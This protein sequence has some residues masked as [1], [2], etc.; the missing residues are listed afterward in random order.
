MELKIKRI[1]R[2]VMMLFMLLFLIIIVL[3]LKNII[4]ARWKPLSSGKDA[5]IDV[6]FPE[7]GDLIFVSES[8]NLKKE[9]SHLDKLENLTLYFT[10][11]LRKN[12]NVSK[13]KNYSALTN[14]NVNTNAK[15]D[16]K[17][18]ANKLEIKIN[19][20]DFD[21]FSNDLKNNNYKLALSYNQPIRNVVGQTNHE[22][23]FII[24]DDIKAPKIKI[25]REGNRFIFLDKKHDSLDTFYVSN[26]FI[27]KSETI[28]ST[29]DSSLF[30]ENW[31]EDSDSI[32]F[33][34][35]LF[36]LLLPACLIVESLL[37]FP[38]IIVF[39]N[40]YS[41]IKKEEIV[42]N[43]DSLMEPYLIESIIDEKIDSINLIITCIIDLV[44]KGNLE[45]VDNN[46]I[47]LKSISNINNVEK[48]IIKLL[49]LDGRDIISLKECI[50]TTIKI[51]DIND[52]IKNDKEFSTALYEKMK[53]IKAMIK[54]ELVKKKI[55]N[56]FWIPFLK[57]IRPIAMYF[58]FMSALFV[59]F[60]S[61]DGMA[62]GN[63]VLFFS[64]TLLVLASYNK[65]NH[66]FALA[67][68]VPT[69]LIELVVISS[70]TFTRIDYVFVL[71]LIVE[72]I[73][74]L[75][76]K[77]ANVYVYTK[78]GREEYKKA[79]IF[80]KFLKNYSL[81]KKRDIDGVIVYDDYLVYATA[82][83]IMSSITKKISQNLVNYNTLLH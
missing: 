8:V 59:S 56:P 72:A 33:S 35:R 43:S 38:L 63:F 82:F 40:N 45:N 80:K 51:S 58:A 20:D 73:I 81:I 71:F 74:I 14:L 67:I 47:T 46:R 76:I 66:Y 79:R 7:N 60:M 57:I 39:I 6:Y 77:K 78:K 62:I 32:I 44:S 61:L 23:S 37:L 36:L 48:N 15:Y 64:T 41:I 10:M 18:V 50:G 19:K 11:P 65:S 22:L 26:S 2:F 31:D 55:I 12:E 69:V 83:G 49:F 29:K 21:I 42:D 27:D 13:D 52:R 24:E 30:F 53:R 1:T 28:I 16:F 4:L 70:F 5:I 68:I 17:I 25:H 34:R 54:D 75:I 9:I 3:V